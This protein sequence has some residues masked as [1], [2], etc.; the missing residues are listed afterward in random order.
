MPNRHT[1]RVN[2]QTDL[3]ITADNVRTGDIYY[4][5][6]RENIVG[7]MDASAR[8]EAVSI[9]EDRFQTAKQQTDD[10]RFKMADWDKQYKGEWRDQNPG[11]RNKEENRI[12]LPKT[13]EE[14][15]SV[16]AFIISMLSQLKPVVSMQPTGSTIIKPEDA[17][18][19]YT[20]AKLNEAMFSYYFND[21]WHAVD[22]VM[23]QWITHFLKY[24]MAILKISYFETEW[25]ADLRLDVVDRAFL[26]FD[27]RA[28][29]VSESGWTI[30]EY[31]LPRSEVYNR[32]D[33]G[34]WV[35]DKS[36]Q[37]FIQSI[38][39]TS[40][41]SEVLDRYFGKRN[42]Q[43]EFVLEDE[44]VQCF[45]Y[46][47]YPRDGLPDVYATVIGGSQ[48]SI[49]GILVRYGRNPYPYKGIPYVAASYNP[50]DR[51]DGQGLAELQEPFQ[52]VSNTFLNLRLDDVR[53]NITQ[54][55][56]VLESMVDK[57][58]QKDLA[59]GNRMVRASPAFTKWI[60]ED[61]T[62]KMSDFMS[63]YPSGTSTQELLTHDLPFILGQSQQSANMPDVF[64]GLNP[65]PGATLGQVQEQISR[66]AGQF[67]PI[68]RQVMRA[69]ERAAEI[70][71]RYFRN[72]EFYP[73]ERMVRIVGKGVYEQDIANWFVAGED[74]A[75][76]SVSADE[77]DV[78]LTFNA[79]SG[80]DALESRTVLTTNIERLF[81]SVGQIP[82]MFALLKEEL[83]FV[84]IFKQLLN[85]SGTDI[86]GM[87]LSDRQKQLRDDERQVALQ[88]QQAML[89]QQQ[90]EQLQL[91][92]MAEEMKAELEIAKEQNKQ[93]AM[94]QKQVTVD[95]NKAN[96]TR[97][98]DEINHDYD[99]DSII[100]KIQAEGL[101]SAQ[102][103]VLQNALDESHTK[104]EAKL[105]LQAA[106]QG[107]SI[108]VGTQGNNVDTPS[109]DA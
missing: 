98:S 91:Q 85:V 1:P 61:P 20:R 41:Q 19:D 50:D 97:A 78:D 10:M 34:Y 49:D 46:W 79:M 35:A 11:R 88:Q 51:P 54:S 15:N 9:I 31:Y 107:Q 82:E 62:R 99:I 16:R 100:T 74:T 56:I 80:I 24:S 73:Q 43:T 3:L 6:D 102:L 66:T 5:N 53:K 57:Q 48:T 83:D 39:S 65:N 17:S 106:K 27:P 69:I 75:Y 30:E 101:S 13:R 59:N 71:T 42:S 38:E 68:L 108:S 18:R 94:A 52:K 22:D 36:Q 2:K 105:E 70:S 63:P 21:I 29:K 37:S 25:A 90:I 7:R 14:I 76:K 89:K 81:Q 96:I 60:M 109:P 67:R 64:R 12:F 47:Q 55:T 87:V 4:R 40:S 23:P 104:L 44:L 72:P 86:E 92:Q 58:T 84:W 26:Y 33:T 28:N 45:D 103:A 93:V 95:M 32:I 77:L 8:S